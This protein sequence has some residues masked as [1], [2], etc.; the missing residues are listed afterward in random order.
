MKVDLG[1]ADELATAVRELRALVAAQA[2]EIAGLRSQL[3][4]VATR[5]PSPVETDIEVTGRR[6]FLALAGGAAAVAAGTMVAK[7]ATPVAAALGD[8]AIE[9]TV[10]ASAGAA[11]STVVDYSPKSSGQVDYFR[12]TDEM[13]SVTGIDPFY[14]RYLPAAVAGHARTTSDRVVT[15]VTGLSEV[16]GGNGVLGIATGADGSYGVWGISET[17]NGVVGRSVSGYDFFADGSGRIGLAAHVFVG[18]PQSGSYT[19]GDI[20]R[21]SQGAVWAC[22]IAGAPGVWRKLA[23]P[24]SA[25]SFHAVSPTRVYDSRW[26]RPNTGF[27]GSNESRT[28]SVADGRRSSNGDVVAADLVP[29]GATAIACNITITD[30]F[31]SGFA[32]VNPGLDSSVGASTINWSHSDQTLANGIIVGIDENRQVTLVVGGG[33][34]TNI[35][36]DVSGYFL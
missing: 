6:R 8:L 36:V 7:G 30:T 27:I 24:T 28:I 15:G 29:A 22:V 12:V 2:V 21:D 10:S 9:S 35:V 34:A 16:A 33:G 25:G 5:A 1:Q 26:P 11:I 19:S 4:A 32:V 17:G 14:G 20:I 13:T 18:P 23:G 31:G 3:T